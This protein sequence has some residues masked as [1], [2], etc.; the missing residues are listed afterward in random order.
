MEQDQS[1]SA[2]ELVHQ[3]TSPGSLVWYDG[4]F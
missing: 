2:G 1:R 4:S 3:F